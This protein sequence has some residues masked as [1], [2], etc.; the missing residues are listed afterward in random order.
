LEG[1]LRASANQEGEA[2]DRRVLKERIG[3]ALATLAPRDRV[4]LEMR[5]GLQDGQ[6]RSLEEI[7][8]EFGLTRERIRQIENRG[9]LR[10][11]DPGRCGLL[12]E[13]VERG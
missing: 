7:A 9:L 12:A 3:E 11:R 1:F 6:P 10:L 2:V 13:F 4:V 5:F 8:R